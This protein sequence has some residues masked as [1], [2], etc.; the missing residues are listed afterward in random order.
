[1]EEIIEEYGNVIAT[2]LFFGGI[3]TVFMT[4][5]DKVIGGVL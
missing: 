2:V 1:M 4:I 5:L 3:M